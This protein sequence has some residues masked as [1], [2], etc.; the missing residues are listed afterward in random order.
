MKDKF[1]DPACSHIYIKKKLVL[2]RYHFCS[3]LHCMYIT[4]HRRLLTL[5]LNFMQELFAG[6]Q[7]VE[8]LPP[9]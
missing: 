4:L 1:F 2:D 6:Y 9:R 5:V 7:E 3:Y 8:S